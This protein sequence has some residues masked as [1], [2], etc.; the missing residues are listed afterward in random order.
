M[1]S[2]C[3]CIEMDMEWSNRLRI[4]KFFQFCG[5]RL[6]SKNILSRNLLYFRI[7]SAI[8]CIMILIWNFS[9]FIRRDIAEYWLI[10]LTQWIAI[11][12]TIYFI[13]ISIL[14]FKLLRYINKNKITSFQLEQNINIQQDSSRSNSS[15]Q[16]TNIDYKFNNNINN[17]S[18]SSSSSSP[19]NIDILFETDYS[20]YYFSKICD[21][22]FP[23]CFSPSIVITFANW[24]LITQYNGYIEKGENYIDDIEKCL[25]DIH[26]HGILL[27][28]LFIDYYISLSYLKYNSIL[29]S[30]VFGLIFII[31]SLVHFAANLLNPWNQ[32]FIYYYLNWKYPQTAIPVTFAILIMN[33]LFHS[34]FSWIKYKYMLAKWKKNLNYKLNCVTSNKLDAKINN[35][36]NNNNNT[37]VNMAIHSNSESGQ[38]NTNTAQ[39]MIVLSPNLVYMYMFAHIFVFI[40][41]ILQY[42]F[43]HLQYLLITKCRKV[44]ISH[45]LNNQPA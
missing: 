13:S 31:W 21:V 9:R 24:T 16:S 23:M 44:T 17:I 40:V 37:V 5:N 22:L 41:C 38:Y 27:I 7:F 35:N 14:N 45:H 15:Q 28:L 8:Y 42:L 29:Y 33:I 20:F 11:I 6:S 32:H 1:S 18:S 25:N 19:I 26:M 39:G 3:K 4:P 10:F 2:K 43:I 30:V 34:L 36:N 12:I